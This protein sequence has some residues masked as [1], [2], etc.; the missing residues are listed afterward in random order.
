MTIYVRHQSKVAHC[1]HLDR[2]KIEIDNKPWYYDIKRYLENGVYLEGVTENDKRTL[3][4]LAFDFFL[5]GAIL[6]KRTHIITNNGTNLNNKI[7]T[8]LCEQFKNLH[9]NFTP[10]YPKMNGAVEATNKNIKKIVQKM[11]V[12]YKEWHDMLPYALH[13]YR[14]SI[15]TSIGAT[16]YSLVYGTNRSRNT[17]L[18]SLERVQIGRC[19]VDSESARLAQPDRCEAVDGSMPRVVVP[20]ENQECFRQ[21]GKTP[22]IQK[23]GLGTQKDAVK[24]QRSKRE[25]NP[26]LRKALYSEARFL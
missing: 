18:E 22:H 23:R 3:R 14:T 5:S 7:M 12:T 24:L 8:K 20:K 9:H 25:V 15:Q 4:R 16:P 1:Q 26:K 21:E 2:D 11:G 17:L 6:Y 10:Y 13:E 19:R